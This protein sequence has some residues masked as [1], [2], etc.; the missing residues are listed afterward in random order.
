MFFQVRPIHSQPEISKTINII[1]L[2]GRFSHTNPGIWSR[3][4]NLA[5]EYISP[6]VN[7]AQ[8]SGKKKDNIYLS[9]STVLHLRSHL[10]FQLRYKV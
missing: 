1:L 2:L 6:H 10:L 9:F 4:I 3:R 8:V 7:S 5:L